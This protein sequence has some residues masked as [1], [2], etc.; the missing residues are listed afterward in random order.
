MSDLFGAIASAVREGDQFKTVEL[1]KD[2]LDAGVPAPD[3]LAMGLIPGMQALG[4][5]F[6]DGQAFLPEILISARAMKM[7]LTELRP[8]LIGS[9][10]EKKGTIVLGTVEGDLHDIGKT[11]VGMLLEG[12]GFNV[13][14]LGVNVTA[15]A[16]VDA[17]RQH[18][19]DVIA[20]S[21]LLT[22][23]TPQFRTVVESL[24]EAGLRGQVKVMVGGAPVSR[25]LADEVGAEGF[26][27]DCVSAV[28][29]AER[30][31]R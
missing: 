9:G 22:T 25:A 26:A 20:L 7:G 3:V 28:D 15:D 30:L 5:L 17:A 8:L 19:A 23:T 24:D 16:F 31:T 12:N 29:E 4:E 18:R 14:D 6:K 2:A 11:L 21:A 1:V 10:V 13:V 27:A